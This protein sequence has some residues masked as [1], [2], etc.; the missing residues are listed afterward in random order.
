MCRHSI[1]QDE[2][3]CNQHIPLLRELRVY[4]TIAL[5]KHPI[6]SGFASRPARKTPASRNHKL[7]RSFDL[8]FSVIVW[9]PA[10]RIQY[11]ALN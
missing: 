8:D 6:P 4:T 9:N 10:F 11:A 2:R 1:P 5:Y 3:A 7:F